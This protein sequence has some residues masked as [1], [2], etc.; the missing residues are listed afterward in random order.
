MQGRFSAIFYLTLSHL[1]TRLPLSAPAEFIQSGFEVG[2]HAWNHRYLTGL[3]VSEQ[4]RETLDAKQCLEDLCGSPVDHFSYP[5]GRWNSNSE[6]A[7]QNAGFLSAANTWPAPN[8]MPG[9]PFR[10]SRISIRNSFDSHTFQ[11]II[12]GEA[13][14]LKKLQGRARR[15]AMLRK[16]TGDSLLDKIRKHLYH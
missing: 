13:D 8:Q 1:G 6:K 3:N 14:V 11:K 5:G 7:I 15:M 9:Q 4:I 16:I 12:Q 10:I 2:C